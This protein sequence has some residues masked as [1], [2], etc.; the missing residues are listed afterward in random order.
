VT[1]LG[2]ILIYTKDA[3]AMVAFY[4]ETF[5]F[6]AVQAPTDRIVEL[7]HPE[8][9][10]SILLHQA[11][12]SQKMGQVLTKLVF[13]VADVAAFAAAHPSFG[14]VHTV[15]GYAFANGKDPSGNSIQVSSRAFKGG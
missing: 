5:G 13:D 7:Q 8:G 3:D 1:V 4:A 12:K 9:G 6:Q 2:R 15:Q 14:K 11:A 10:A